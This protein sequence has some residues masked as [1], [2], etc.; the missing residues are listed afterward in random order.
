MQISF[1]GP[2]AYSETVLAD[3]AFIVFILPP[4]DR[5]RFDQAAIFTLFLGLETVHVVL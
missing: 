5:T 4:Q 3:G 2:L 1:P